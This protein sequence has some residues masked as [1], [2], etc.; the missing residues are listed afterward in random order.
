MDEY[1]DINW[2]QNEIIEL[3]NQDNHCLM[4]V[5]DESQTIY[6]FRG[7]KIDYINKFEVN[8]PNCRIYKIRYNYRSQKDIVDFTVDSINNNYQ[9]ISI[10]RK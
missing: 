7:S 5:G 9:S 10:Q 2:L 1:Q 6:S 8:H 4:V 3:I